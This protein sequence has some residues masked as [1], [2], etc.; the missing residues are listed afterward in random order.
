MSL[1]YFLIYILFINLIGFITM[2]V[3]K[4]KARKGA[5]RISEKVIFII[6]FVL[7][8]IGVY[9]GIYKFRHK[10]KHTLFTV[11]I[12]IMIILNTICFYYIIKMFYVIYK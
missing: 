6:A 9:V 11:G 10:T 7:G 1:L 12:P 5:W 8:A 2:Y 4:K 3:D